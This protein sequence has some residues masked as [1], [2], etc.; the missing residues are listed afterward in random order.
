MLLLHYSRGNRKLVTTSICA[1][2]LGSAFRL[3]NDMVRSVNCDFYMYADDA[4]LVI[5]GNNGNML[6]M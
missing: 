2:M 5:S 3:N 4:T 1:P 6:V